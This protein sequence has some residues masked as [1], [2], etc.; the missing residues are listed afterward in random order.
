M[1][2]IRNGKEQKWTWNEYASQSLSFAKALR[3]IGVEDRRSI[4]IMGFNCPEWA[5][6]CFGAIFNNNVVSGVYITNGVQACHY[7]AEHSMAEVIVVDTVDQL[8]LYLSIIDKLPLVKAI[9]AWGV[10]KI[11]DELAKDSRV[12]SFKSFMELGKQI[13]LQEIN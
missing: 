10:E 5:I 2:I 1:K 9:V 7:Q 6:A 3:H 12:Y 11:P 13:T 8:K 4:N